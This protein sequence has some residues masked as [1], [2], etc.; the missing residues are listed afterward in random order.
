MQKAIRVFVLCWLSA[1]CLEA[2]FVPLGL[3]SV[4]NTTFNTFPLLLNGNLFP[5]GSQTYGGVPFNIG[6][7]WSADVAAGGVRNQGLEQVVIPINTF[8]VTTLYTLLNSEWGKPSGTFAS[9]ILTFSNGSTYTVGLAGNQAIRDY[10]NFSWTNTVL[11]SWSDGNGLMDSTAMAWSDDGMPCNSQTGTG[12]TCSILS[13]HYQRLDEQTINIPVSLQSLTLVSLTVVDGGD[14]AT[15][16]D[17]QIP[18]PSDAQRSFIGGLSISTG[19]GPVPEPGTWIL[20]LGGAGAMMVARRKR[21][22]R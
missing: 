19:V 10:N 17:A 9:L 5:T 14:H 7:V 13:G 15:T 12:T 11:G 18:N 3:G 8:G 2:G 4:A 22:A 21:R 6:P 20:L 1:V 16:Q